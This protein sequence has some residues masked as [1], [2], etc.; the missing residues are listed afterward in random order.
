ML[1]QGRIVVFDILD[2]GHHAS[3]LQTTLRVLVIQGKRW[4]IIIIA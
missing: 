2:D 1:K 3:T 4:R